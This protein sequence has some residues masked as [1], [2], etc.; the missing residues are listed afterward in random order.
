VTV[1]VPVALGGDG[2]ASDG[3]VVQVERFGVHHLS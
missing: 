3:G 1:P 2:G